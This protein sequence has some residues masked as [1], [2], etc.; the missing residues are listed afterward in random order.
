MFPISL[1]YFDMDKGSNS[2]DKTS[3][4]G[5]RTYDP[6]C[7][8]RN[9]GIRPNQWLYSPNAT[10]IED[11]AVKYFKKRQKARFDATNS[12]VRLTFSAESVNFVSTSSFIILHIGARTHH[13]RLLS[14]RRKGLQR[15]NIIAEW[16]RLLTVPT[17]WHSLDARRA[18]S[19]TRVALTSHATRNPV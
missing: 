17:I 19:F 16:N 3:R 9:L 15:V 4:S 12:K 6:S 14:E 8:M 18:R 5:W 13:F 11:N 10:R 2:S 7:S 1:Q